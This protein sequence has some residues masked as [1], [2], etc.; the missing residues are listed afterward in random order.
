MIRSGFAYSDLAMSTWS[1]DSVSHELFSSEAARAYV[2]EQR[3]LQDI[4]HGRAVT[5]AMSGSQP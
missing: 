1:E 4:R 3:R 5:P 2:G